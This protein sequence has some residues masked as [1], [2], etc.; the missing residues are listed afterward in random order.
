MRTWIAAACALALVAVP[1]TATA[2]PSRHA[3]KPTVTIGFV[4][5]AVPGAS[6]LWNGQAT[7][8]ETGQVTVVGMKLAPPDLTIA[9]IFQGSDQTRSFVA[10]LSGT[11]DTTGH[12]SLTGTV[13]G[14]WLAHAHTHLEA[15]ASADLS[16]VVGTIAIDR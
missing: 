1:V 13:L 6:Y 4:K 15:Q 3:A 8:G 5:D 7:S 11:I 9:F 16:H 10:Q 2:A 12:I 14:G